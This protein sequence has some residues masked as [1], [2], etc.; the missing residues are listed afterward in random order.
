[1]AP[2]SL[3]FLIL[4]LINKQPCWHLPAVSVQEDENNIGAVFVYSGRRRR[5]DYHLNTYMYRY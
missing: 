4:T 2:S 3:I 5:D 1:M